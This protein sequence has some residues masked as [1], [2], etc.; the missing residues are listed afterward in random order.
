MG[1][2]AVFTAILGVEQKFLS[3]AYFDV[4]LLAFYMKI[5]REVLQ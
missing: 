5:F 2:I 4:S 1:A 3:L